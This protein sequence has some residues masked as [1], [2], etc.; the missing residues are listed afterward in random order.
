MNKSFWKLYFIL[1][2]CIGSLSLKGEAAQYTGHN[3]LVIS[4]HDC[5]AMDNAAFPDTV[6]P[7]DL[8]KQFQWLKANGYHPVSIEQIIKSQKTGK[9]LP[10]NAVLLTFDDGYDSFYE[11]VY[12]LLK[13]YNFP[14][15]LAIVGK[16]IDTPL[17]KRVKFANTEI[18]RDRF[19]TWDKI[20][21]MQQ[22]GLVEIASH[23]YDHHHGIRANPQGNVQAA[24]TTRLY[25]EENNTYE[26]KENYRKR[27]RHDMAKNSATIQKHLGKR[28]R[29]MV[30]PYGRYNKETLDIAKE[31]GM[32]ITITLDK[33]LA[34]T[35]NL[36][37]I[38]R[39]YVLRHRN[40]LDIRQDIKQIIAPDP[41]LIRSIRVD[42]DYVYDP[43]P[44]Q[45][46]K[47]L[48][49]L[50]SRIYKYQ[51]NTV[52][53]QGYCDV[54]AKGY[55]RQLYFPNRHL[56]MK[57]DLMN[58]VAW[59][60][61]S[62]ANVSV[63]AW[64]PISGFDL[65]NDTHL[66]KQQNPDGS[67]SVNPEQY[68][69]LS[70][71][72]PVAQQKIKEI[73]ED[74][75]CF[76]PLAGIAFHDDGVLNDFEDASPYAIE[77]QVKAGFP[78]NIMEIK[79]NPEVFHKWTRWKSESLTNFT[80]DLI[81]ILKQYHPALKSTRSLFALPVLQPHSEE[82]FAQNYNDFLMT[83]DFTALMAM[84]YMEGHANN[85]DEWIAQLL[86]KTQEHPLGIT[87]TLFELQTI[88]WDQ[89]NTP[90]DSETLLHQMKFLASNGV[91]NFGY[92]PDDFLTNHPNINIIKEGISIQQ[93]LFLP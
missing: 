61:A 56:P 52:F 15:V 40:L 73:Y 24:Y 59:Q 4:Y 76:V 51:I 27:I 86:A 39:Y 81:K 25:S 93:D 32:S 33:G 20:K 47:N 89:G 67:T 41:P 3:F 78:A 65:G 64:M 79:E 46:E 34:T 23:S 13:A 69:R 14:A 44:A 80:K 8:E 72:S 83:Y 29:I 75:G 9:P 36:E 38:P 77:A 84:P 30:W 74:L 37:N 16:W 66:V 88:R 26:N 17:T 1:L 87:R 70:I 71:Y 49:V 62:R 54:D 92:Y 85:P 82:W 53:L 2:L 60:L 7:E 43:D 91:R 12:P 42:L 57:A 11:K 18:S 31:L 55:A 68:K 5:Q 58:R 28:P 48:D 22:S 10:D 50:I 19:L 6:Y 63:Y 35:N 90:I 21:E 45:I